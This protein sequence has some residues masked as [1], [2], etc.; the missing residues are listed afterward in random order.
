[1]ETT[2]HILY[3]NTPDSLSI[4]PR[5]SKPSPIN[6]NT[7]EHKLDATNKHP[8]ETSSGVGYVDSATFTIIAGI[9]GTT[10]VPKV[11]LDINRYVELLS[12]H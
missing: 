9:V 5:V 2:S 4:T 10:S 12:L 6:T 7:M 1:M 11:A 8:S 3:G